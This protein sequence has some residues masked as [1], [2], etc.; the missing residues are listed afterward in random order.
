MNSIAAEPIVT[1]EELLEMPEAGQYE[2]VDGQLVERAMSS[3]SSFVAGNLFFLLKL[4]LRQSEAGW[5]FPADAGIQCFPD[6]ATRVRRPDVLF[7]RRGKLPDGPGKGHLKV[8]PDL[9]VEVLSPHELAYDV[10][11]KILEYRG[12]GVSL[13]WIVNPDTRQLR[14]HRRDGSITEIG[15]EGELSG[16]DVL[17]D[18]RCSV[19][20]LFT[21][22]KQDAAPPT[23]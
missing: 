2:L 5:A 19:A 15:P 13:I 17:P 9:V 8:A 7:V 3:E 20:E 1:P 6:D 4:H 16:E 23:A 10:D 12:A 14:I 18:F 21:G 22:L 11:Q